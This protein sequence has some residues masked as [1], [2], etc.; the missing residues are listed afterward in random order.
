ML[1]NSDSLSQMELSKIEK[2]LQDFFQVACSDL[3][4]L[5]DLVDKG[6]QRSHRAVRSDQRF[7]ISKRSPIFRYKRYL[8]LASFEN[9]SYEKESMDLDDQNR[10]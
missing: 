4:L 5:D 9:V 1:S 10:G 6:Q 8:Y 2:N 7:A 3:I